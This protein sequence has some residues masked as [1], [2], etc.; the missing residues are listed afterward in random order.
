LILGANLQNGTIDTEQFVNLP[1]AVKGALAASMVDKSSNV[2]VYA[3]DSL[4]VSPGLALIG[5]VQF[6]HAVRDRR[7]R[8]L[9]NGD[10]SGRKSYDLWSPRFGVLWDA[11]ANAQLFANIS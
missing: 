6:L 4:Y 7:D 11:G 5:G 9:S 10:Q 2:S 3:E 8:F 1:G